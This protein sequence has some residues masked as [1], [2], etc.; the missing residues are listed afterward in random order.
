MFGRVARR[1]DLANHLLSGGLDF[2]W[3]RRA[4][5]IVRQWQPR[6]V[7]DLATGSGDLALTIA[8]KLP[9]AKITGADFSPE[10][11]AAARAKGLTNTVVADALHLPFGDA[12]FDAVTVAFGLRNMADWGAA[13]AEMARV[14][15]P[16]GHLLVLDFSLPRGPL[17]PLYRFY[18]HRCLPFVAGLVTRQKE[19]YDYLGASIEKFPSGEEMCELIR[20]G[21]FAEATA[22]PLSGG[23]VTIYRARQA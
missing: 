9:E 12:S 11:L 2:W 14:L 13:L 6:R 4:A 23:V 19:A 5:E 17:R 22:Q 21:G 7:L 16:G 1:Y 18:L 15:V 3:R 10:M 8:R 20:R